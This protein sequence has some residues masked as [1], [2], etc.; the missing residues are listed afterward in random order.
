MGSIS[1]ES[2][3]VIDVGGITFP[4]YVGSSVLVEYDAYPIV[5]EGAAILSQDNL[6]AG[7]NWLKTK[8]NKIDLNHS[9]DISEA[10][11]KYLVPKD[12]EAEIDD[13]E[14]NSI[15]QEIEVKTQEQINEAYSDYRK[16]L[17]VPDAELSSRDEY[18]RLVS[19]NSA[20]LQNVTDVEV[21]KIIQSEFMRRVN[22]L[23][24]VAVS[25]KVGQGVDLESYL[26]SQYANIV[27]DSLISEDAVE[28]NS[29]L[30]IENSSQIIRHS[31]AVRTSKGV[32]LVQRT[33]Q[34]RV[35]SSIQSV[36]GSSSHMSRQVRDASPV[37]SSNTGV[38]SNESDHLVLPNVI[39]S[40]ES[41]KEVTAGSFSKISS[42]IN[43]VL[44]SEE[45]ASLLKSMSTAS[46]PD[47][48]NSISIKAANES[49]AISRG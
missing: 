6:N 40:E 37:V 1:E 16:K 8:L 38:V 32:K 41:A 45:Q 15:V 35:T 46:E 13:T 10:R 39:N 26:V 7:Y 31:V 49:K 34:A 18:K 2:I 27:T 29:N 12:E 44:S 43:E 19:E 36:T 28:E 14:Y 5:A 24:E 48:V 4:P 42:Q 3:D 23:R 33:G 30:N 17:L 21:M 11:K 20:K 9:K 22:D 25:E 47:S